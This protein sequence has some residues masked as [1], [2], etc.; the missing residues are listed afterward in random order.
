MKHTKPLAASFGLIVAGV[1]GLSLNANSGTIDAVSGSSI[2]VTSGTTTTTTATLN[3]TFDQSG[4]TWRMY[5]DVT[6]HTA[7]SGFPK[8][9]AT[10]TRVFKLTG[11]T[12]ATK[13]FYW[14]VVVD[15]SGSHKSGNLHTTKT[16]FT[17]D[18]TASVLENTRQPSLQGY[19]P[20][21][22]M[23]RRLQQGRSFAPVQLTPVGAEIQVKQ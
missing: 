8:S 18:A 5:Y 12:P 10:T 9:A 4:G 19:Q 15:P 6:D 7:T 21:D 11:L 1:L 2:K 13:Y 14:I 22:A 3:C 17:T 20:V 23:G 16:V